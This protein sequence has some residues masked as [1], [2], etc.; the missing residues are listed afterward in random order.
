M[1]IRT[2]LVAIFAVQLALVVGIAGIA[3]R[4]NQTQMDTEE[5]E[6]RR[7]TSYLLAEEM[8]QSSDD[9]TRFA[10]TY[11]S[12]GDSRYMDFFERV[13][14]IRNGEAPRPPGYD[15]V[16]WHTFVGKEGSVGDLDQGEA[17]SLRDR[18]LAAGFTTGEFAKLAE[19][20][21]KSDSLVRLEDVAMNALVGRFD[22]G[23]GSFA[24]RGEPDP[25][26]AVDLLHGEEYHVAKS[27]IMTP[28]G[29]FL[30]LIDRRTEAE[31]D[32]LN[33][34]ERELE[35]LNLILS[36]LLLISTV[37]SLGLIVQRVLRPIEGL[38]GTARK[39]SA[40]DLDARAPEVSGAELTA[41]TDT[42]NRMVGSL[43]NQINEVTDA[44][45]RIAAQA[46]DLDRQRQQSERLLLNVLPASIADRIKGGES[47]IAESFPEVSVCFSDIVGFTAMSERIGARQVV[48]MLNEIFSLLD[49]LT[50]KHRVEKIKTIGDCYMVVAGAP[51]RSPTH[52]Q[53]IAAF[54]LDL[55]ETLAQYSQSSGRDI[56][57]RTGV[58]TGT[59]VAGII[60]TSKMSYDLWGDVVNVASRMESTS[61]PGRIQVSD[62]VRVRLQ[63]DYD[64]ESRGTIELRNRGTME[65]FF[66]TGLR[67]RDEAPT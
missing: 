35:G 56:A 32:A 30:A 64:F 7:F 62:A 43:E 17:M 14:A 59:V 40:G 8:R 21:S 57:M 29:E 1:R 53:Q 50:E 9:L 19:S 15:S 20:Q 10:R 23:T 5:A 24:I 11:V 25:E 27:Q 22:D 38:V 36:G 2:M 3:V 12:T 4:M 13:L 18:M 46:E 65:T 39:V 67:D 26:R 28:L 54:A 58:H 47:S 51:D 44:R 37:A 49:K 61:L 31:L 48:D 52:A 55:Q 60:G 33:Q 6:K 63:D 45:E 16:F 41:L 42:F 66:L 34:R